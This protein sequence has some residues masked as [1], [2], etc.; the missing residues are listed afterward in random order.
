MI[1]CCLSLAAGGGLAVLA[2]AESP[3]PDAFLDQPFPASVPWETHT[4]PPPGFPGP[5][6]TFQMLN[7]PSFW[8]GVQLLGKMSGKTV[9]LPEGLSEWPDERSESNWGLGLGAGNKDTVR[10][11]FNRLCLA[12]NLVWRHDARQ[13]VIDLDP[14]WRRS[15]P[16]SAKDLADV[17]V[18][19]KP[20]PED[21]LPAGEVNLVG[22][23]DRARDDW[24]LA[25][26]A[27]LSRPENFLL[28]G[29]LR[30]YHDTHGHS[31]GM[32]PLDVVNRFAGKL[33]DG[34]GH[35]EILVL[36]GQQS[37]M[38]KEDPGDL[39]YY[40]FDEEGRFLR[41]GVYAMTEGWTGAIT[42]VEATSEGGIT[43]AVGKGSFASNP[44]FY[45]FALVRGDF[46]LQ[47]STDENGK[48]RNAEDT[49][50]A[51]HSREG[52]SVRLKYSVP[53]KEGS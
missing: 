13:D 4:E 18:G 8:G 51:L 10:E 32:A 9:R 52:D 5:K 3:K 25:F 12:L 38:N 26:D 22:G 33:P 37:M 34:N 42:K 53:A 39:A 1:S 23:R 2:R 21:Q 6:Q 49:R 43:V 40:L 44:D 7:V 46:V 17:L 16:H 29:A 41:G 35:L 31:R 45:H 27:L 28:A 30:L 19:T 14:A 20:V 50:K 48:A 47:G 15:D 36:N 24:R 11:M